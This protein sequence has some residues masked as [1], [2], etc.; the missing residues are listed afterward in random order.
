MTDLFDLTKVAVVTG[1]SRGMGRE[2]VLAFAQHGADVVASARSMREDLAEEVESTAGGRYCRM[3]CCIGTSAMP[4]ST[5]STTSSGAA[6]YWST[7]QVFH[8][9]SVAVRSNRRP[10][11]QSNGCEPRTFPSLRRV[12]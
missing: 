6:T 1:G 4:W 7:T 3:S 9:V 11:H 12:R 10:L 8:L 2:M 5:L